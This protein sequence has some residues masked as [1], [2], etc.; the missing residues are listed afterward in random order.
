MSQKRLT[1]TPLLN[2]FIVFFSTGVNKDDVYKEILHHFPLLEDGVP[3][4][5][6][7]SVLNLVVEE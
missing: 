4:V 6:L 5:D 7:E 3:G 1:Q 2:T